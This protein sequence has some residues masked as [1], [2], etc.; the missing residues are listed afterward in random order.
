MFFL[1]NGHG[2]SYHWSKMETIFPHYNCPKP[3]HLTGAFQEW[4]GWVAGGCWDYH[5]NKYTQTGWWFEPLWKN[6]SQLKWLFPIYGK[7]K[8]ATKPP[9]SKIIKIRMTSKSFPSIPIHSR[10]VNSTSSSSIRT[11]SGG[12]CCL[13][14]SAVV[15]LHPIN[16]QRT[17]TWKKN[18]GI[19]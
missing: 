19:S 8:M 16:L 7:I 13:H 1:N 18:H 6:I 14:Q 11:D 2:Q 10:Y 3:F 9:T 17:K 12:W 15:K 5:K 4:N